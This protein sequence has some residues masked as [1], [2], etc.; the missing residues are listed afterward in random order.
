MRLGQLL[1]Q[2]ELDTVGERLQQAEGT[3][4]RG[5]PAVLYVRRNLALQPD[6]VGHRRQQ[7]TNHGKRLDDR[8]DNERRYAQRVSV[9]RGR[10]RP[11][12]FDPKS[13]SAS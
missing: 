13:V 2:D 10:P 5:A 9:W 12:G 4:S 11:R 7:N 1:F 3:N 8:N 6:A